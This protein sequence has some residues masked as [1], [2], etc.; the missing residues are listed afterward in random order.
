MAVRKNFL[1][2]SAKSKVKILSKTGEIP[3]DLFRDRVLFTNCRCLRLKSANTIFVHEETRDRKRTSIFTIAHTENQNFS[4]YAIGTEF[5][6]T[7]LFWGDVSA[8]G[9]QEMYTMTPIARFARINSKLRIW[10]LKISFPTLVSW[11]YCISWIFWGRFLKIKCRFWVNIGDF[12]AVV[13]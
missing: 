1:I 8:R 5:L 3:A 7:K 9:D 6:R 12:C 4:V 2:F 13:F 10:F 11:I